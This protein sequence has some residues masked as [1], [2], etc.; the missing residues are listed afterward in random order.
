MVKK[1]VGLMLFVP[2]MISALIP[3]PQDGSILNPSSITV[4]PAW[5]AEM[6]SQTYSAYGMRV[7]GGG[8]IDGDGYDDV[9]VGAENYD[10]GEAD[11]GL[12]Q[13]FYGSSS[14]LS[15]TP[16][17]STESNQANAYYGRS[18]SIVG[19]L[20][21]DGYDDVAVGAHY[22]DDGSTNEGAVFVF[23]GSPMGLKDTADYV[24][25]INK[26]NSMFGYS[27]AG[28]GDVNGDGFDDLLVGA[29][30]YDTITS[31]EGGVFLYYGSSTG[32]SNPYSWH[33]LGDQNREMLGNA[34]SSA[35]DVNGDGFDDILIGIW[36]YTNGD[37]IEGRIN[38]FYGSA[39]GLASTADWY[40][41]IDQESVYFGYSVAC[42]GDVNGDGY[43]DIIASAPYCDELYH[44]NG[45]VW[46]YYGSSTGLPAEVSWKQL[47]DQAAGAFGWSVSYA[48]DINDDG[49][50][51]VIIGAPYYD[52][53]ES[54]EGCAFLYYGSSEGLM[55]SS[56]WMGQ[57]NQSNANFGYFVSG[58]GDVNGDGRPDI[59]VGSPYYKTF[60]RAYL[61]YSYPELHVQNRFYDFSYL[62]INY[63]YYSAGIMLTN[64]DTLQFSLDSVKYSDNRFTTVSPAFPTL[65]PASDSIGFTIKA[66]S[67]DTGQKYS[68]AKIFF[69][70]DG[71]EK[72]GAVDV[73]AYFSTPLLIDSAKAF[74]GT[75]VVV[76]IDDDDYAVLYFNRKTNSPL[77]DSSNIDAVLNLSAGHTWLDMA[78]RLASAVWS[79]DSM[80]LT[81]S[82]TVASGIP[83]V[84]VGD[85]IYPDSSSIIDAYRGFYCYRPV[86]IT[87]DFSS[88]MKH[89]ESF[90]AAGEKYES[91][92]RI[93]GS[94]VYY[95][96]G[97]MRNSFKVID[98][99]G[100]VVFSSMNSSAGTHIYNG[101]SLNSGI[102]FIKYEEGSEKYSSKLLHI[103]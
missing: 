1:Y 43:D 7:N 10:N 83:T 60:G 91:S 53:P 29:P 15:S 44:Q 95:T 23:Y 56:G 103:K 13:V 14:G 57:P 62:E 66:Q 86:V 6:S 80:T 47:G 85:T 81:I 27:V 98:I 22:Y 92:L 41:E 4:D 37:S 69:N 36:R 58:G 68:S 34:V 31:D 26:S 39:A 99:T 70:Y 93:F 76:G 19:D 82:F 96:S 11:E 21:S 84:E 9:I 17:W 89:E 101:S 78:S 18:A 97:G 8:D 67:A 20:N 16:G 3:N 38:V 48:G 88:S 74:E 65:L 73:A 24:L 12:A 87:G 63:P 71:I 32:V 42:A 40:A 30:Y 75:N 33:V 49:Y 59:L 64:I 55:H 90:M 25:E 54:Q 2:V 45:G 100:K 52:N 46:G 35:G 51:D 77:I 61:Y 28:A 72:E 102:Y 79:S 94:M 5:T 50:D